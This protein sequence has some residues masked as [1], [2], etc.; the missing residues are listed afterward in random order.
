M[1]GP[2]KSKPAAHGAVKTFT[3]EAT[4]ALKLAYREAAR[5]KHRSVATD[6]LLIGLMEQTQGLAMKILAAKAIDLDALRSQVIKLAEERSRAGQAR[7][8]AGF[9]GLCRGAVESVRSMLALPNRLRYSLRVKKALALAL[10]E[11]GELGQAQAGSEHVLL[12][13]IR[14]R[15]GNVPRLLKSLGIDLEGAR[16][17][18]AACQGRSEQL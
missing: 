8:R 3:P 11:A 7:G 2:R 10:R 6:H 18:V 14:E 12:G 15:D 9:G 13:L 1:N 17:T 4:Q 16:K 5:L